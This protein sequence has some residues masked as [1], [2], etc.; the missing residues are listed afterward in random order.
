[1]V[2]LLGECSYR[3]EDS[4]CRFNVGRVLVINDPPAAAATAAAVTL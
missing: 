1:M 4:V 2:L 3:G